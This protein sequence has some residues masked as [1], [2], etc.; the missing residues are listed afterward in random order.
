MKSTLSDF[1]TAADAAAIMGMNVRYIRRLC[2][3]NKLENVRFGKVFMVVKSAAE[4]Y[5]RDPYGRGRPKAS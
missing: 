1:V 3:A 2:A 5:K 4:A